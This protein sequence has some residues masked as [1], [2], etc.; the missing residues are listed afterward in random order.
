MDKAT[1]KLYLPRDLK[2]AAFAAFAWHDL[3]F[4]A[5]AREQLEQWL[6]DIKV[7]G[8]ALSP[9]DQGREQTSGGRRG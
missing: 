2:R 1:V 6:H 8:E 9:S 4:S 5:W 7:P 3:T